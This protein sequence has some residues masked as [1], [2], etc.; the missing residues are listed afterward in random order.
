MKTPFASP[1]T[2]GWQVFR[3]ALKVFLTEPSLDSNTQVS[4]SLEARKDEFIPDD[5]R[6]EICSLVLQVGVR[7]ADHDN[8]CKLPT[9]VVEFLHCQLGRVALAE[10]VGRE[11]VTAGIWEIDYV[12]GNDV[13]TAGYG[14]YTN[15]RTRLRRGLERESQLRKLSRSPLFGGR[16]NFAALD[17]GMISSLLRS[18]EGESEQLATPAAETAEP[19]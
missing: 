7:S 1:T 11:E 5:H 12:D 17:L 13:G 10:M 19:K 6:Q 14:I 15:D 9:P 4:A 8:D 2:P 16:R 18:I 3:D